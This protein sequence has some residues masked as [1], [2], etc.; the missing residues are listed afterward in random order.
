MIPLNH[1]H[2]SFLKAA[3]LGREFCA[4]GGETLKEA[5]TSD[6][7]YPQTNRASH[8]PARNGHV[9]NL[10]M[11]STDN[12]DQFALQKSRTI[13][14]ID[15]FLISSFGFFFL[16]FFYLLFFLFYLFSLFFFSLPFSFFKWQCSLPSMFLT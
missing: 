10:I 16:F 15:P 6:H 12:S 3:C 13:S 1:F 11:S 7:P 9:L 5:W 4:L 8:W 14:F 2:S